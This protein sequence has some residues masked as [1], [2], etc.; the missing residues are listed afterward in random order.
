MTAYITPFSKNPHHPFLTSTN[1]R[2]PEQSSHLY[3]GKE[4][5][6]LSSWLEAGVEPHP[7]VHGIAVALII[8]LPQPAQRLDEVEAGELKLHVPLHLTLRA[9]LQSLQHLK[10]EGEGGGGEGVT[11]VIC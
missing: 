6:E 9:H 2:S 10:E 1:A 7:T 3:S 11:G 5:L 4:V 8:L